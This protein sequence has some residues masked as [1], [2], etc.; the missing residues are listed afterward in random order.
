VPGVFISYRRDDS[1]GFAGRLADDLGEKFGADLVFM[2]VTGIAPGID[3]R[4]AIES[5]VGDCD[6]VLVVI[7]RSWLG[8]R[9]GDARLQDAT[10]VVRLEVASALRRDVAV[11]PVLVD[12]A[13]CRPRAI[14]LPTSNRSRGATLSS[15]GI[16]AGMPIFRSSS[17]PWRNSC[18]ARL[19]RRPAPRPSE[20]RS[21]RAPPRRAAPIGAGCGRSPRPRWS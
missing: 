12:G 21:R 20:Q 10:D 8:G 2:D 1:A 14:F 4:K 9:G 15:C 17:T 5:K 11:I 19:P 7:G 18:R 6:A 13:T 16:R 3:F